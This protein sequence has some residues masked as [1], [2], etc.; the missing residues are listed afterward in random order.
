MVRRHYWNEVTA[1]LAIAGS[2]TI[3]HWRDEV[4]VADAGFVRC[5]YLLTVPPEL[6]DASRG[7]VA[8]LSPLAR[9]AVSRAGR[10]PRRR[11]GALAGRNRRRLR[12]RRLRGRREDVPGLVRVRGTARPSPSPR[13]GGGWIGVE[14]GRA[15]GLETADGL[16]P[17][18]QIV[19][20]AGAWTNDLLRGAHDTIW[21]S[22][23]L[24][25][26]SATTSTGRCTGARSS[27]RPACLLDPL[28]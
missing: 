28:S 14:G 25:A 24:N 8:L 10:D 17:T 19:L 18:S 22:S 16:V 6:V 5:G 26:M 13:A 12:A 3:M 21:L 7:N 1:R 2:R 20:A 23:Q 11:A 4:G 9:D 15:V 27:L